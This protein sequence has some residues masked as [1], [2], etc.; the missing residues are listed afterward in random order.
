L[1]DG[2]QGEDRGQSFWPASFGRAGRTPQ[3]N[4]VTA[5][6]GTFKGAPGGSLDAH[7]FESTHAFGATVGRSAEEKIATHVPASARTAT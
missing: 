6:L 7:R 5:G 3:Q 1:I 4:V 2:E